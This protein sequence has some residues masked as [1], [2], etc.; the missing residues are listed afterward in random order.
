MTYSI[1]VPATVATA[2]RTGRQGQDFEFSSDV[3]LA[4]GTA[5]RAITNRHIYAVT[6][7][8]S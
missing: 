7:N 4:N 8:A 3:D 6:A 1:R 5:H 2:T